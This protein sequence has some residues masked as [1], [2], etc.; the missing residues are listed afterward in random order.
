MKKSRF[1]ETQI[2]SILKEV[3]AGMKVETVCRKHGISNATYYN[4]KSKYGGMDTSELK[5]M[6]E[7]EEENAKLK[8]MFADVSLQNQAM[9]E[10]FAKKGW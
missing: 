8:K 9:K 3:D 10:L 4:W 5:R 1:T 2:F 7:L 6:R